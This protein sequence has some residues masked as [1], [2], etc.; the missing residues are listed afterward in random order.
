MRN[1]VTGI[2][3]VA[4]C[5]ATASA[6]AQQSDAVTEYLKRAPY[7]ETFDYMMQYTGGDPAKTLTSGCRAR[8]L[9]SRKPVKT[10][11]CE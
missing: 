11:S 9:S 10:S 4:L 8:S 1:L 2:S 5:L 3:F 6:N 7:Q